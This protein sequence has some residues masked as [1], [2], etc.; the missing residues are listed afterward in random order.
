M[1]DHYHD[2]VLR[3]QAVTDYGVVVK[4]NI[5]MEETLCVMAMTLQC[6]TKIGGEETLDLSKMT[7]K[8]ITP[9]I[10]TANEAII[11]TEEKQ[12]NLVNQ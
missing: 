9:M 7:P 8:E 10:K 12:S 11:E 2:E 5:I 4:Q 1:A 6:C 3:Q